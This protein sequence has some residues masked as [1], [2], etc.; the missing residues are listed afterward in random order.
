MANLDNNKLQMTFMPNTIEHLGAR[1]YSTLP[2]VLAELIANAYDADAKEVRIHLVDN[3]DKVITIR[4]NGHGM[5]LDD[6]NTKFLRI[7]RNRREDES[8]QKSI[9]G[10]PV[11]GKKGLGKLSFFGIAHIIEVSTTKDGKRNTFILNWTDIINKNKNE[12][13][14]YEPVIK[15]SNVTD[16]NESCTTITLSDIQRVSDFDS[17]ALADSLSKIFI[18]DPDF[19]IYIQRND[20]KEILLEN[21]RKYSTLTKEIEWDVPS[22][23]GVD[24]DYSRASEIIGHLIATKTPISP[25]TNMRG[26]TLFSRKKLVN[27]PEYFSPST[28]SHFYSYLTGWLEVDFIDDLDEDVIE[29]NRQSLDWDHPEI[30][31]LRVYLQ[32]LI[33]WL[34][35]DWRSQRSAIRDSKIENETNINVTEW[36]K[37]V[38]ENLKGTLDKLIK[39]LESNIENPEKEEDAIKGF[40]SLYEILPPYA[41]F[42]WRHLHPKLQTV[43]FDY[44]KAENYYHAVFEGVKEYINE[45]QIKSSSILIDRDLL[46]NVFSLSNPKLSVTDKFKRVG[47]ADFH[48]DTP[49]NIIEGHRQLCIAMWQA[50]RDPLSHETVADLRDSGLYTEQDCLNALSLLSHLFCRLENSV[51]VVA[52]S[53]TI[54]AT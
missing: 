23:V 3:A 10:R 15:E 4:D 6:I 21:E 46:Q 52:V 47:G 44:Y 40:Q 31:E 12:L 17:E 34:E 24:T 41:S 49:K 5:S 20:D 43:V 42:H 35:S 53:V 45:V 11:I 7:G 1:L 14:N 28:S 9:G 51:P 26:I 37:T 13:A 50:F 32:K 36:K 27:L 18:I 30:A 8:S 22:G 16:T 38:P 2:P 29:T 33:R 54:P 39:S 19:N 48:P 25:S